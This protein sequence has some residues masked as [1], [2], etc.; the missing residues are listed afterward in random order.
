[1]GSRL[2]V[3]RPAQVLV[4]SR[5]LNEALK[6]GGQGHRPRSAHSL[7]AGLSQ[8]PP[9]TLRSIGGWGCGESR[10]AGWA[11]VSRQGQAGTTAVLMSHKEFAFESQDSGESREPLKISE[12]ESYCS[13]SVLWKN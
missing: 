6:V 9:N 2:I 1:M 11:V 12:W 13:R 7:E 5:A 4:M 8:E 3:I 10:A